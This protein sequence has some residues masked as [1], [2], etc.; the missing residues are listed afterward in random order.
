M[1]LPNKR[2]QRDRLRRGNRGDFHEGLLG[3][4]GRPLFLLTIW[5]QRLVQLRARKLCAASQNDAVVT[6]PVGSA[7]PV[8]SRAGQT[9][10]GVV[11]Q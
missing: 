9:N 2:M 8:L 3:L 4:P 10:W 6:P 1:L 7:G 5:F 11:Y